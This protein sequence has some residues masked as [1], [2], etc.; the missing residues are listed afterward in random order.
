LKAFLF[1][2]L[3]FKVVSK[4]F[5][6]IF[7]STNRLKGQFGCP[8]KDVTEAASDICSAIIAVIGLYLTA[9]NLHLSMLQASAR[10]R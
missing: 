7:V 8:E 10:K 9:R 2:R 4:L 1:F 3:N 5:K 6:V